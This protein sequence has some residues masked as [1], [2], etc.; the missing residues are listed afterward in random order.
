MKLSIVIPVFNEKKTVAEIISRVEHAPLSGAEKE[1]ILVDD[2][3]TDGTREILSKYAS[4]HT[5]IMHHQN[6]GKGA[7]LRTGFAAATGDYVLVQ[8]ADLEYDPNEYEKLLDPV[9]RFGADVVLGSRFVGENAHRVVYF[10][11]YVGNKIL[12]VLSNM[13]TNL[14]LTDMETCY[15]LI[16]R[17]LLEHITIE[18]NR[19]G[20][21]PEIVSKLA[22]IPDIKIFEVGVS[23]N[24][25]TYKEGKKINW[26]D[27]FQAI[28]CI[29]RYGL[30]KRSSLPLLGLWLF[31]FANII[32]FSLCFGFHS[33]N[34]TNSF[35]WT[36][37][38][39]RGIDA[40]LHPNRYL[41][42][43]YPVISATV[44]RWVSPQ[45]SIAII[46][47]V[48]YILLGLFTYGLIRRVFKN[49]IIGLWSTIIILSAYPM[50]RYG[51]TLVQDIGG[52]LFFVL[53]AY[54][55]WRWH[56]QKK[57]IWLYNAGIATALGLLTKESGAMAALFVGVLLVADSA[58]IK[59]LC[60]RL[61]KYAAIPLVA[62]VS[63]QLIGSMIGYS[64]LEWLW[65]NWKTYAQENYTVIKW[66][67]VN[68]TAF[69][70]MWIAFVVGVGALFSQWKKIDSSIKL[71]IAAMIVP[72][73]SYAA[74][75]VFIGRTVFISAWLLV[76]VGVYGLYYLATQKRS[77][78]KVVYVFVAV[79][80]IVPYVLQA[81]VRYA[82][83]FAIAQRCQYHVVC[84]WNYFWEHRDQFSVTGDANS[85][86]YRADQ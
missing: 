41:N 25:R 33:N 23:Y 50:L 6:Q 45:S 7:A 46:N 5:V 71:F 1:I 27:G 74:W 26:K 72:A 18:Q 82:N 57:D 36:I 69:N 8:D 54:A 53:T 64:S 9:K 22:R 48:A 10:W 34:D 35:V 30:Q 75:P 3:S 60:G 19:F 24:G 68:L 80:V 42:P 49:N 73:F 63:G 77:L 17:S 31:M 83:L 47:V 28:Y 51:L 86:D 29:V 56:E 43:L 2:G 32:A 76:P 44:L 70:V 66:L 78:K 81:T 62:V 79:A 12:T 20:F 38:R 39:F 58:R 65:W 59:E 15:K 61:I 14:N 16:R 85:F 4:T 67:G 84:G 13:F 52:Y 11:H 21:E 37:E 40:P 55:G